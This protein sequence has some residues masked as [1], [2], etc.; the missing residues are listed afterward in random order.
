MPGLL[1]AWRPPETKDGDTMAAVG[2]ALSVGRDSSC[3]WSIPDALLSRTHFQVERSTTGF[4]VRD[5]GSRNGVRVGGTRIDEPVAV[6]DGDVIRAGSH[7]FVFI[8]DLLSLTSRITSDSDLMA[9]EF[10][11]PP[12]VRRLHVAARTG[13]HVLLEGESGTGK[14]LA[15]TLLHRLL[16]TLGRTGRLLAHNSACFAGE[17][18]AVGTVFGVVRGAFTGV[19]ERTG[20]LELAHG[21]TL[22]LDEVHNLPLR[23]QRSLLRFIDDQSTMPL[24]GQVDRGNHFDVRLVLGTNLPV[25][26]SCA[27]GELAPDLI[28]R[29]HRVKIS[30]LRERRADIPAIFLHVLRRSLDPGTFEQVSRQF[31][32]AMVERLCLHDYRLGNVRELQDLAS[33]I[34]AR[35][36][37]GEPPSTALSEAIDEALGAEVANDPPLDPGNSDL[38][39]SLYTRHRDEIIATYHAAQGNVSHLESLLDEQGIHCTRRWLTIY[40]DRWGVRPIRRRK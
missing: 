9:G 12:V 5:L 26:A 17:D 25:E 13:R 31:D 27:Q 33:V 4:L 36:A 32:A 20:A 19:S 14:E 40:L 6:S 2:D 11:S 3:G 23:V 18:D 24:G 7:V 22:F 10:H 34:G 28:A 35:I 30:P 15:A 1:V 38:N 21:G 29:L 37:V 8:A 16:G 39:D